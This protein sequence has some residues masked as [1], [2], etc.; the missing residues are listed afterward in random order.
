[1]TAASPEG[2]AETIRLW[3]LTEDTLLEAGEDGSLVAITWWG[4][5]DFPD[6]SEGVRESLARLALGPVSMAN[7]TVSGR[8]TD[9]EA[10]QRSLRKVLHGLSGSVVHSLALH[11]GRGPLLS[12]I[13]VIQ[14]PVFAAD[15]LPPDRQ[16]RFSRFVALRPERGSLLA[17][18]PGARYQVVLSRPPAV[19]I[20][21]L[22]AAPVSVTHLAELTGLSEA[23][24]ADVVSFLVAAGLVLAADDEGVFTEAGDPELAVWSHDDLMFHARS[25]TWRKGAQPDPAARS[26]G[27]PP[28]VKQVSAG[29]TFPLP[30]PDLAERDTGTLTS[31]LESD[32]YCPD[33]S[34][35]PL[36]AAQIGEFLYR[37]ARV[38][39]VGPAHLPGGPSREVSQRPYF[40]VA[41]LYELEIYVGLN[42]CG[43]LARG[44]Y[45]YD[46][47]WHTLT[48][49]NDEAVILDGLL[50]MAMIA[51][52]SHRR[53]SALLTMTARMSRVSWA[54]GGAAY[55]T[56]LL[57][58]GALQQVLYLT[59]KTMGLAAHAVPVDAGDRVDR[60]LKLEWPAEVSVGECVLDFP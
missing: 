57:H 3:S 24:V 29:P 16:I 10:W 17:E 32:H 60:A 27:E 1:L 9:V 28:V 5:Y 39:S 36:S 12:A 33:F 46:P 38:R 8:R 19:L 31:L 41:C 18:S 44:I 20:A 43:D 37:A 59:A 23:V 58:V 22:L 2:R 48:L 45:H 55:A 15:T 35:R 50:D 52:G 25:R 13:P 49:I 42:R 34:E 6:L 47:L 53:P 4:E 14:S 51:A 21:S 7:L 56:T 26:G 11:D 30:R 54:L 40:S